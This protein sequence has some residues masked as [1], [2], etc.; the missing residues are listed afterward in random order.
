MHLRRGFP[1]LGH[2]ELLHPAG[3]IR[4]W[5]CL[6]LKR[7]LQSGADRPSVGS[8]HCVANTAICA[9]LYCTNRI[10]PRLFKTNNPSDMLVTTITPLS[11]N[12]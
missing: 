12:G 5:A 8:T 4:L 1:T 11:K 9:P 2:V 6:H 10:G 7:S 3:D